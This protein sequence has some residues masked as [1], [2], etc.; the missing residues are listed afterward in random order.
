LLE[1]QTYNGKRKKVSQGPKSIVQVR[2][3]ILTSIM[4]DLSA[5]AS[6]QTWIKN[7][8]QRFLSLPNPLKQLFETHGLQVLSNLFD[9][10]E[11]SLIQAAS[12]HGLTCSK[13]S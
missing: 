7:A 9:N 10:R 13:S 4:K 5:K 2:K 6:I 1:E 11:D 12:E 8:A 3:S